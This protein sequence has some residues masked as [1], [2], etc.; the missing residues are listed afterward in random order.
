M[1]YFKK[2]KPLLSF[3]IFILAILFIPTG[4]FGA[5]YFIDG[6]LRKNTVVIE[7]VKPLK[8]TKSVIIKGKI[9]NKGKIDFKKCLIEIKI[10]KTSKNRLHAMLYQLKPIKKMSILL[11]RH[12]K[13]GSGVSFKTMIND[14]KYEKYYSVVPSAKCY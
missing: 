8:Y 14:I 10:V 9:T 3:V 6:K 1:F 7:T 5:K 2:S 12:I 4:F 11:D 13:K